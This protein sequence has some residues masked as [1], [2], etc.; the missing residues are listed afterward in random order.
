MF[1]LVHQGYVI[2]G[3]FIWSR[4]KFEEALEED[5]E[6]IHALPDKMEL[7][8]PYTIDENTKIY[9]VA[10]GT[11]VPHNPRIEARHGPF[12]TFTDT[13]A[14][15]HFEPLLLELQA[16]KNLLMLE[17]AAERWRKENLGVKVTIQGT[18]YSFASDRDTRN[19]LLNALNSSLNELNWKVNSTTWLTLTS[20]DIQTILQ[21]ILTYVQ[22]CFDWE[23]T[24]IETIQSFTTH[25]QLVDIVIREPEPTPSLPGV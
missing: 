17:V 15:Y 12:W 16:A 19:I 13:H 22:T 21:T 25:Q 3:P 18:E 23:K 10:P 11:D 6:I 4:K 8:V 5:L 7:N 9:S 24:T 20:S 14:V 1:V 2:L